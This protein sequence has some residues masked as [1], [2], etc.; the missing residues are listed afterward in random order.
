MVNDIIKNSG[1]SNLA[2]QQN[3]TKWDVYLGW[4][5]ADGKLGVNAYV[6]N[7]SN[8]VT[9]ANYTAPYVS[10]DAPRTFGIVANVRL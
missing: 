8:V 4:D 7:L 5:S 9:L 10:I 3:Y 1:S 6:K 2:W